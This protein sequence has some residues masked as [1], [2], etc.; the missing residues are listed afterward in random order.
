VCVYGSHPNY[1]AAESLP[2]E[3][4]RTTVPN[5]VQRWVEGETGRRVLRWRR[6]PG[7][8]TSAVHAV[9]L[10][11]DS[12]AVLR[13]WVWRWVLLDEPDVAQRELDALAVAASAALPAPRVIAADPTGEKVGDGVPVLLMTKLAGSP[14]DKPDPH[15][16]AEA[17]AKIHTVDAPDLRHEFFRWCMDALTEPPPGASDP[18]LWERALELRRTAMPNYTAVLIHRDYNPGNVLW[19]RGRVSGV[20]DWALACR[21]PWEC[22]VATCRRNLLRLL[23]PAAADRFLDA[24]TSLTGRVFNP[25]WDLNYLLEND[26]EHW[27]TETVRRSGP[28]LRRILTELDAMG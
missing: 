14:V 5:A 11:D 6:L 21:G 23:A 27:T 22:D 7:A 18:R 3:L 19:L 26:V 25:Y 12:I 1:Q 13:R 15:R 4:R 2:I 16:L 20:V 17:A 24:Y 9:R 28:D 10:S 8:S